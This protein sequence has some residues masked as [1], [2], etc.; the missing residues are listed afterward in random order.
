MTRPIAAGLAIVAFALA[1]GAAHAAEWRSDPAAS[2]V[3]FSATFEGSAVPGVFK[4]FD[5]RLDLDAERVAA[6]SLVVTIQV[7][8]A[9]L[10]IEDVNREIA[11]KTWFDYAAFPNAEFRSSEVRRVAGD[12]YVARG[13]L[14]LKGVAQ[15]VSVPF[16][17]AEVPGGAR[18]AGELA[19]ER[20][21]FG[22]GTGEWAATRVIGPEVKVAFRVALVK[23]R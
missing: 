22:I 15:P 2:K 5:A 8:S 9:D 4:S 11:S 14:V 10:G 18:I 13:T 17:F 6:G 1:T 7:S 23:A 21:M 19:L 20:A 16:T 12:R 3:G